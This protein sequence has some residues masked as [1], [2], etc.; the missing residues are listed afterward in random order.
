MSFDKVV[1]SGLQCAILDAAEVVESLDSF[2]EFIVCSSINL[3]EVIMLSLVCGVNVGVIVVL[4]CLCDSLH[5]ICDSL[6][7]SLDVCILLSRLT[8]HECVIDSGLESVDLLKLLGEF[9]QVV[10]S[11]VREVFV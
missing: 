7:L 9:C 6:Q 5:S 11:F 10:S 1:E 3:K 2:R 4:G 8:L